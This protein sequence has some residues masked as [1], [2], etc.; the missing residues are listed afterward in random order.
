M[1][2]NYNTDDTIVALA[3]PNG[4]G[5]ISVVRLSGVQSIAIVQRFFSN[6]SLLDADSHTVHYGYIFNTENVKIDEVLISIFRAPRSYTTED[7]VEIS[8]HGSPYIV[9]QII[10]VCQNHGARL[11]QEGEFTLR[12]F[13]HGRIDL[14]QAEAVA[15]MIAVQN[16]AQKDIALK[17]LKGGLSQDISY[18]RDQ[19]LQLTSLLELE[20][21]FGEEDV[22]FADRSTLSMMV[23][24]TIEHLD[25]LIASFRYGNAIKKGI[26]VAIVGR[27]NA[28]KS[29]LLNVLLN[30]NRAI[31]TEIPG[32]TRDTIEEQFTIQGIS[33]RLIDTAGIRDTDDIVEKIGVA[34]THATIQDAAIIIYL[35]D[36]QNMNEEDVMEDVKKIIFEDKKYIVCANKIDLLEEGYAM[37]ALQD[38][39]HNS[40]LSEKI[41]T[42]KISTKIKDSLNTLHEVLVADYIKQLNHGDT[43]LTNQRHYQSLLE[44]REALRTVERSME[45]CA[46]TDLIALDLRRALFSLGDITGEITN[47]EVLGN[48]FSRF[49]IGK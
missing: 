31:V 9:E 17:Q 42:I 11:A 33:F 36:V 28:G 2:N 40:I 7:I 14:T 37:E 41:S 20:L 46:S 1:Q 27:P 32:T 10:E 29:S 24:N 48:I 4:V 23:Q 35:Y 5:A 19:L 18:Y 16:K 21:D 13:L 34:K 45:A 30:D 44:A 38:K 25:P 8:T 6:H 26:P 43:I 12:A 3:T 39:L 49:C 15:D 47:D 22:A